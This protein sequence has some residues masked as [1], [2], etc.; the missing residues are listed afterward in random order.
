MNVPAGSF[1]CAHF[2]WHFPEFTPIDI[3]NNGKDCSPV[4]L[5]WDELES[6]NV[7]SEFDGN[8]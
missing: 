6:D 1:S 2:R 7:L 3:W 5:R 4:K 8:I